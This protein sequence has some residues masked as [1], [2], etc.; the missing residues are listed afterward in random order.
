MKTKFKLLAALAVTVAL[1]SCKKPD[2]GPAGPT[3]SQGPGGPVLT[4][5][6]KGY[7]THYDVSGVK[8]LTNLSGDTVKID[9]TSNI[10]VTD[11][12]GMYVFNGLTTGN[13]NLTINKSSFGST[14]VQSIPFAGGGDLYRN[15]NLSRIPTTNVTSA[16]A[17][18]ATILSINNITVSGTITPQPFVQTV[19]IFV[20]NPG[21][22]SVS[23]NS[24]S[25]I[26][27]YTQNV[28]P[29][30]TTFSK[31]IPTYEFYDLGYASGNV[32]NFAAYMV[33]SNT[34]ASTYV[35]IT[36]NRTVYTA[37]S[38]APA[39]ASVMLQ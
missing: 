25:N 16:T 3:G 14:K 39:T 29:N 20:G 9:G 31:N 13:Y 4:G 5:N 8:M 23:G 21:S 7:I 1:T 15:A 35:D 33:G 17:I 12:N 38:A 37:I 18:T 19:I 28:T 22:T 30:A 24:G 10:A 36:N 27:A 34:N 26:T 6:L 2:A 32:A 11:A